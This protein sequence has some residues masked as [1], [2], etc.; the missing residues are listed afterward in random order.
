MN[1][2]TFVKSYP[3]ISETF[4][5]NQVNFLDSKVYCQ[6][7]GEI[8]DESLT[9]NLILGDLPLFQKIIK[10]VLNRLNFYYDPLT[11]K[12]KEKLFH[13]LSSDSIDLMLIQY[14]ANAIKVFDTCI[15]LSIPYIIHFHGYDLSSLTKMKRYE[16]LLEEAIF[17]SSAIIV[18]NT[19]QKDFLYEKFEFNSNVYILPCGVDV[20][21]FKK[22]KRI[23]NSKCVFIMVGRLTPKK[24]PLITL[25]AFELTADKNKDIELI[26]IGDG[27]LKKEL[28]KKLSLSRH[29]NKVKYLGS[30]RSDEV[31]RHLSNS[32]VFL[33]HSVT[34]N[35]GDKEGWPISIAE[36]CSMSLPVVS[37]KHSGIK[38]QVI[39][40]KNGYLVD[41]FDYEMM[42]S[43]MLKLSKDLALRNKMGNESRDYISKKG[44]LKDQLFSLKNIITR[45]AIK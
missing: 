24:A 22:T 2:A 28:L 41:E 26:I 32:D 21:L 16:N 7:R 9:P 34:A 8:K 44:N 23:D 5:R 43:Y 12:Q 11:K 30:C 3:E 38:D 33:Q 10:I 17:N 39:H 29:R 35:N 40:N 4:I 27:I 36:A 6:L 42:S 13:R 19:N 15:K 31:R 25:K 1:I 20:K 37:T 18:V 14:G 45:V